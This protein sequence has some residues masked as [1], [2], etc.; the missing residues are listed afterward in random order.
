[1]G[2]FDKLFREKKRIIG[3]FNI[4]KEVKC[5][6]CSRKILLIKKWKTEH[7]YLD[8]NDLERQLSE[9]SEPLQCGTCG[10][11]YAHFCTRRRY[12]GAEAITSRGV[13]RSGVRCL[14]GAMNYQINPEFVT[15]GNPKRFYEVVEMRELV[16]RGDIDELTKFLEDK[17]Q[18]KYPEDTV[19]M[20]IYITRRVIEA[21]GEVGDEHA[22]ERLII[23]LKGEELPYL[24]RKPWGKMD[25]ISP[26]V[27]ALGKTG[28]RRAVEPLIKVLQDYPW[29]RDEVLQRARLYVIEGLGNIGDDRAVEPLIKVLNDCRQELEQDVVP[30]GKKELE[31]TVEALDR[32]GDVRAIEPL[33]A[34]IRA[35]ED[36]E[37]YRRDHVMHQ[38]AKETLER[39][40]GKDKKYATSSK[41]GSSNGP[42]SQE[43]GENNK[44]G[45]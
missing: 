44:T 33:E 6:G 38:R 22:V 16:K 19:E 30:L 28:D 31:K 26:V 37:G 29:E 15:I 2:M 9:L 8:L 35:L 23:M 7:G 41:R 43:K 14:C 39:I 21:L 18:R 32:V 25:I 10:R 4:E 5:S 40:R 17:Y 3:E 42:Q 45:S 11:F 24:L 36:R 20:D 34:L 1:M 27:R 12:I 13:Y